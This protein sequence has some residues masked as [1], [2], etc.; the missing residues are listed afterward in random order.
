VKGWDCIKHSFDRFRND[1]NHRQHKVLQ[2]MLET[3][4]EFEGGINAR[5]YISITSTSKATATRDLQDLVQKGV[6]ISRG[7]AGR[8][9]SYDVSF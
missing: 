7:T 9:T 3:D 4:A 2:K 5:N 1:L 8:S 6:L